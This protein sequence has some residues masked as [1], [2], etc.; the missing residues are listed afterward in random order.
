M[1]L[2][3]HVRELFFTL[4]KQH[5]VKLHTQALQAPF[6][7]KKNK[8]PNVVPPQINPQTKK[9]LNKLYTHIIYL[10]I[11]L[12]CVYRSRDDFGLGRVGYNT[13]TTGEKTFSVD[14][15]FTSARTILL[16]STMHSKLSRTWYL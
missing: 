4:S 10:K 14:H 15:E 2:Q 7:T 12:S 3:T 1:Y 9:K 6:K 16:D 8:N 5:H 13:V 11:Y